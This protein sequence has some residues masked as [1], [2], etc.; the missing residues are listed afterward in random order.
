MVKTNHLRGTLPSWSFLILYMKLSHP[1]HK[2]ELIFLSFEDILSGRKLHSTQLHSSPIVHEIG[3][4]KA[5]VFVAYFLPNW[6]L[7]I[8]FYMQSKSVTAISCGKSRVNEGDVASKFPYIVQQIKPTHFDQWWGELGEGITICRCV[9]CTALRNRHGVGCDWWPR[10]GM[11][12]FCSFV[13]PPYRFCCSFPF[14]GSV[15]GGNFQC[16]WVGMIARWRF[17]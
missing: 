3:K 15:S 2:L 17:S 7:D 12:T 13:G 1:M 14:C 16:V 11:H 4:S 10:C 5:S 8:A 6:R 9:A